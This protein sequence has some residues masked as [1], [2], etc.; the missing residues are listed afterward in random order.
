MLILLSIVSLAAAFDTIYVP[1]EKRLKNRFKAGA[2]QRDQTDKY[3]F[4]HLAIYFN[5]SMPV[6]WK[7]ILKV[8]SKI[9]EVLNNT[10]PSKNYQRLKIKY[11]L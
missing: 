8:G 5:E 1:R 4:K 10:P 11:I 6:L 3:F 9:V 7:K 2:K